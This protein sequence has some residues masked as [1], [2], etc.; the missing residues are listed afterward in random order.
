MLIKSVETEKVFHA[1]VHVHVHL[2]N[3]LLILYHAQTYCVSLE[4]ARK[5]KLN[6]LN[7]KYY[8]CEILMF[9]KIVN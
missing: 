5:R 6:S 4:T 3:L 7:S 9:L 1:R 8:S 2:H